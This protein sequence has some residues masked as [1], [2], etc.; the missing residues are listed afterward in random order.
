MTDAFRDYSSLISGLTAADNEK[1]NQAITV[2][3][4]KAGI[5]S[6]TKILGE[7]KLFLSGKPALQKLERTLLNQH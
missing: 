5:D 2:A 7:T 3:Q 4:T 6:T 1:T